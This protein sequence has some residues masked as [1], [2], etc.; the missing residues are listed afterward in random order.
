MFDNVVEQGT[1]VGILLLAYAMNVGM[2]VLR[3]Q[4]NDPHQLMSAGLVHTPLATYFSYAALPCIVWPALYVGLMD[5]WI[6]AIVS[7]L[8]LQGLGAIAVVKL[9]IRGRQQ[10]IHLILGCVALPIGYYLTISSL[11][12]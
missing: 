4:L 12:T 3:T 8:L 5:G 10:A 2:E 1:V 9:G 6:S 7:W 11:S